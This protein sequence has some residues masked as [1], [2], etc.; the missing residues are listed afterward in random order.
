MSRQKGKIIAVESDEEI[1]S[2]P[3]L[4]GPLDPQN[5]ST[6]VGPSPNIVTLEYPRPETILPPSECE[7][8]GNRGGQASGSGENRGFGE[9]EIPEE[10]D[11][12]EE[13]NSRPI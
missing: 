4:F 7:P 10:K 12:D 11:G 8:S 1:D 13:S 3:N 9:A 5:A 2:Y 6:N